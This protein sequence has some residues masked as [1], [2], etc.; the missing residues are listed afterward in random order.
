MKHV[1]KHISSSNQVFST[2]T[3]T[4]RLV[5]TCKGHQF[6]VLD[7]AGGSGQAITR[8]SFMLKTR[9]AAVLLHRP[10]KNKHPSESATNSRAEG[11]SGLT[12]KDWLLLKD[13]NGTSVG[14]TLHYRRN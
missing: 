4:Q 6:R 12:V 11:F 7:G 2:H 5:H 9:L 10:Q 14:N 1:R 8:S 13:Q 3:H